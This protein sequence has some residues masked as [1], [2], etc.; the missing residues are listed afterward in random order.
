MLKSKRK[1]VKTHRHICNLVWRSLPPDNKSLPPDN[2]TIRIVPLRCL[3][4]TFCKLW[5]ADRD[6]T[7]NRS[8]A[9]LSQTQ[10]SSCLLH[11]KASKNL[12]ALTTSKPHRPTRPAG[13]VALASPNH[14]PLPPLKRPILTLWNSLRRDAKG[15]RT[16]MMM[17]AR[18]MPN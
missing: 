4:I 12:L 7:K 10:D 18:C 16:A 13:P 2:K 17:R 9:D 3:K 14:A 1:K 15:S 5:D 11:R 8:I 6:A